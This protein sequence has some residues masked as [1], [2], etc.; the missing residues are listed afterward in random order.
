MPASPDLLFHDNLTHWQSRKGYPALIGIV[1]NPDGAVCALLR[2]Y[3]QQDPND[4]SR[5]TKASLPN[6]RMMLGKVSGGAVRLAE[7]GTDGLLGLCEGIETGLAVM[8]GCPELPVWATLSTSHLEQVH[9]PPQAHT[10]FIIADND[11]SGAGSRA[12]ETTAHRLRAE[13]RRVVIVTPPQTGDDFN[14]LLLQEGQAAILA[15]VR[16]AWEAQTSQQAQPPAL[17]GHHLPLGFQQPVSLLPVLRADEGD[18]ARAVDRVWALLQESN[19][20]PWLFRAAS[21]PSWIV[22]D[23]DGCPHP[24][25]VTEERLRHMLARLANWCRLN[26]NGELVPTPPPL[27]VVKSLLA[28]PDPGLP[29]LSG[30]VS[31]P[32]FGRSGILLTEPGYHPDARLY[33]NAAPDFQIPALPQ[34]PSGEQIAEARVLLLDDLL[35]DFP[36]TGEA[37]R[38]HAVALL[39]LGFVRSMIDGPTPLHLIEKPSPGTG[40]T[41]MVDAIATILTGSSATVMSGGPG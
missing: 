34:Q 4:A 14:D 13:G 25:Q 23:D 27:N 20:Q 7:I 5:V 32:V 35:G 24:A 17:N 1:R 6:A 39:L 9:L 37:E 38:A 33:Y 11:P 22:P 30:I 26:R 28:T 2:T 29:I 31:A 10:V 12:A 15:E 19:R 3:L 16:D 40:A 8:T 36:F 21:L 41:M 18:L